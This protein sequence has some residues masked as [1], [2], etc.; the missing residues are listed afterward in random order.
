MQVA[1]KVE[2]VVS[3]SDGK[4]SK[5]LLAK[6]SYDIAISTIDELYSDI[7]SADTHEE[8][9]IVDRHGRVQIPQQFLEKI[10]AGKKIKA[11]LEE[12]NIILHR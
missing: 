2:R 4:I 11:R 1:H 7:N 6:E 5:E 12:E 10:K 8:F 9:L 3:I